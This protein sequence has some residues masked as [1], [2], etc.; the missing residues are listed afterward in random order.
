MF[1]SIGISLIELCT[2]A[3]HICRLVIYFDCNM[4]RYKA[5]LQYQLDDSIEGHDF[6]ETGDF[7]HSFEVKASDDLQG[8]VLYDNKTFSSDVAKISLCDVE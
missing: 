4:F 7:D 1:D 3:A 2:G 6:G 5:V 8:R